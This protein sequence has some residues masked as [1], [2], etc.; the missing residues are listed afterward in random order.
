MLLIDMLP[1]RSR[2]IDKPTGSSLGNASIYNATTTAA[3]K[4]MKNIK[5]GIGIE[6]LLSVFPSHNGGINNPKATPK[7]VEAHANP[8]TVDT[9]FE[10][11]HVRAKFDGAANVIDCVIAQNSWPSNTTPKLLPRLPKYRTNVPEQF[12]TAAN[13]NPLLRPYFSKSHL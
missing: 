7:Y 5:L 6:F 12:K 10:G 2:L 11:N 1:E 4:K 13:N 9:I 8:T 3:V